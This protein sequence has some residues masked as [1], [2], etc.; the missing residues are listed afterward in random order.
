MLPSSQGFGGQ[1]MDWTRFSRWRVRAAAEILVSALLAYAVALYCI[2]FSFSIGRLSLPADFDDVVYLASGQDWLTGFSQRGV[3]GTL[4]AIISQHAPVHTLIAALSYR[5]AGPFD[6]PAYAANGVLLALTLFGVMRF[7][8][9]ESRSFVTAAFVTLCLLAVPFFQQAVTEFRPDP[10]AGIVTGF[11]VLLLFQ[12][13]VYRLSPNVQFRLGLLLGLALLMKPSVFLASGF[14]LTLAVLFSCAAFLIEDRAALGAH[15][16]AILQ[17]VARLFLGAM[18]VFG[19]Y[20]LLQGAEILGYAYEALFTL[21]DVNDYQGTSLEHASFY[22]TGPGGGLALGPWFWIGLATMALRLGVCAWSDSSRLPTLGASYLMLLVIYL[23][24]TLTAVKHYFLGSM[25]Y[26]SFAL[27]MAR[28][29]AWLA[30]HLKVDVDGILFPYGAVILALLVLIQRAFIPT[31]SLATAYLDE[32]VRRMVQETSGQ[33]LQLARDKTAAQADKTAPLTIL[34][35]TANPARVGAVALQASREGLRVRFVP[36]GLYART[37]EE[38]LS[39]AKA[40]DIIVVGAPIGEA[41]PGSLLGD[42]F[43]AA[44][45]ADKTFRSLPPLLDGRIQLYEKNATPAAPLAR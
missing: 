21:A 2:D 19:P 17:A 43:Q 42:E 23:V 27:F 15:R 9:H 36:A 4:A 8:K 24:L 29:W 3:F 31:F 7:L 44:M 12:Q 6:W 11:A 35:N 40:A 26:A 20:L 14:I 32:N 39:L 25:F 18:L 45:A 28:D 37:A 34:S 16:A 41:Y 10:F 30:E 38:F 13:P 1:R 33:V 5:L 22:I